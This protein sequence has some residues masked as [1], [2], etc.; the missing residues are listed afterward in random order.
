MTFEAFKTVIEKELSEELKAEETS[1]SVKAVT[2]NNGVKRYGISFKD[3]KGIVCPVIYL[4]S[5]YNRF[6][7]GKTIGDIIYEIKELFYEYRLTEPVNFEYIYDFDKVKD[8]IYMRVLNAENNEEIMKKAPFL[9]MEDLIAVF[10]IKIKNEAI[11]E[12]SIL[13]HK[14]FME[15]WNTDITQIAI[16]AIKNEKKQHYDLVSM[17]SILQEYIDN[18]DDLP[19]D[20]REEFLERLNLCD[21]LPVYILTNKDRY[22]GAAKIFDVDVM[23]ELKDKMG[24]DF[25]IIPSSVH[26]LILVPDNTE[27]GCVS[28]E[29]LNEIVKEVNMTEVSPCDVLSDHIYYFDS[30]IKKVMSVV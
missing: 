2:K 1:V 29:R 20:V 7:A 30:S 23:L 13:V 12:G 18:S 14:E 27:K 16:E 6:T 17:G 10:Y 26:E 4:E 21:K 19:E 8:S 28:S 9:T 22:Y 11:G 15:Y 3:N 5:F 25:Y 24:S